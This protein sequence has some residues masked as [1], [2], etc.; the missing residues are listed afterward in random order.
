[1]GQ[2]PFTLLLRMSG[3]CLSTCASSLPLLRQHAILTFIKFRQGQ[4]DAT[5]DDGR[6]VYLKAVTTNSDELKIGKMFSQ[7]PLRNLPQNHCVP[8]LDSFP[9][10]EGDVTY[11]VMPFLHPMNEP[12]FYLVQDVVDFVDQVLEVTNLPFF[13]VSNLTNSSGTG[14][15]A[16]T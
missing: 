2:R 16:Q 12:P 11:M 14:V 10:I 5:T 15:H 1:M 7:W 6:L 3:F 13:A 9:D 4:I 8:I